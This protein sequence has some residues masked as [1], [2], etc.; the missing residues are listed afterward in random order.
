[1]PDVNLAGGD[2]SGKLN[3]GAFCMN[4]DDLNLTFT[5]NEIE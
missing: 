1:M 3:P 2:I 5:G 4:Q